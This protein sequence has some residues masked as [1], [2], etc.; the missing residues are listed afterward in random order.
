MLGV[1]NNDDGNYSLFLPTD[2]GKEF[3][4]IYP[5]NWSFQ[6]GWS[7][8]IRPIL[9]IWK[10]EKNLAKDPAI[11]EDCLFCWRKD[12]ESLHC[13][14]GGK[15]LWMLFGVCGHGWNMV[16]QG[17]DHKEKPWFGANIKARFFMDDFT[18]G[19]LNDSGD[20]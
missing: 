10:G 8:M 6:N 12:G 17:F 5:S 14:Y 19:I 11:P 2:A 15:G 3:S 7:E 18:E 1:N 20:F 4:N 9:S 16:V 13:P